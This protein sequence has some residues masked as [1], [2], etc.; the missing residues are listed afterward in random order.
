MARRQFVQLCEC[1]WLAGSSGRESLALLLRQSPGQQH[2]AK[3]AGLAFESA[4]ATIAP[5]RDARD[6]EMIV[7]ELDPYVRVRW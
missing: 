3:I 5:R 6:I 1:L 2:I 4:E 7:A